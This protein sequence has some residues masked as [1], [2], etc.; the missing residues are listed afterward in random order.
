MLLLQRRCVSQTEQAYRQSAATDV[1]LRP[2]SHTQLR[3]AVVSTLVIRALTFKMFTITR[4]F[5]ISFQ[6]F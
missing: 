3:S 4:Y 5:C 2:Y 1:D 6:S